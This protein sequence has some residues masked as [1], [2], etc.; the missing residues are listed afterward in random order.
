MISRAQKV[1]LYLCSV[2]CLFWALPA[3]SQPADTIRVL[4]IRVQF[5]TD[6]EPTTTG[7]GTFDLRRDDTMF[8]ID[9]A[10]H[11]R[12]YF[13]DHLRFLQNYYLKVSNRQL[14]VEGDVFPLGRNDAY[15]L[16]N[17]M[18]FY[19]PN[20]TEDEINQGLARLLRDGILKADEDA[21][22]DF[23]RYD[24]FI[25]FH[26]GVGRDIDVGLDDTPQDI[27]SLFI[28]PGFLQT[29][30]GQ[31][32]IPVDNGNFTVDSGI[33]LP[34]TE[35]QEGLELGL[36]GILVSNFGSQLGWLDLFS[37]ETGRSGVG[38]FGV[39]DAG[40]F[41]GD[42]LLPA[43]PTAWTRVSNG[44]A[45]PR[46]IRQAQG[47]VFT[48]HAAGTNGENQ[49]YLVPINQNEYFL[50]E[51]RYAGDISLDSL[52]AVLIDQQNR[53]V[54]MREV[55]ET[56][57]PG[58]ATFSDSTGVLVDVDNP[59][60]GLPGGGILIWHIDEQV[61]AA[62]R[63]ANRI[64][65]DPD[66]R[67]VD[68]EE[69]DGSQDIGEDFEIISGGAGS[70]IGYSLDPWFADNDTPVFEEEPAGTFSV[71]SI[72]SSRSNYNRANSHISV[73]D[74][75]PRDSV[76]TFSVDYNILQPSFPRF[77]DTQ[78]YGRPTGVKVFDVDARPGAEIIVTT[79]Q[80]Q[81]LAFNADRSLISL[82]DSVSLVQLPGAIVGLPALLFTGAVGEPAFAVT[83]GDGNIYGFVIALVT[84][85][86]DTLFR[87]NVG[88][89]ITTFPVTGPLAETA[90]Q[91]ANLVVFGAADG[92][93]YAVTG[94]RPAF[95]LET[96]FNIGQPVRAVQPL[97]GGSFLVIGN[98]GSVFRDGDLDRLL[99]G[100]T[101]QPVGLNSVVSLANSELITL[102][103]P[104]FSQSTAGTFRF[105][106][107]VIALGETNPFTN[108]VQESYAVA[109]NNRLY[110]FNENLSLRTDFPLP[111]YND[112]T[113]AQ[114][115]VS[116]IA[117]SLANF[118]NQNRQGIVFSDPAGV[119]GAAYLDGTAAED[120]PLAAGDS[121]AG[122]P[123]LADIDADGDN[124]LVAVTV[125]G[126]VFAWDLSGDAL[127]QDLWPQENGDAYNRNIS[128]FY[129]NASMLAQDALL[130]ENL[131]YNW[132]NPNVE[133]FTYIR[134][135]LNGPAA[136]TI[137]IFD[138]AGDLVAELD[139]PQV[140]YSDNEVRWNLTDV[141]SGVYFARISAEGNSEKQVN[142]VKIAVIK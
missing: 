48:V 110:V 55:L 88:S 77:V 91:D 67:G 1:S 5:V 68:L 86:V 23:S 69:A 139:A 117:G 109:G 24:S 43:L 63:N 95:Q 100:A 33:L 70:E 105:D 131:A 123:A 42:G 108:N 87:F 57:L 99:S 66:H 45:E 120:F 106:S 65:A 35:S 13:Q 31:A 73:S 16:D 40:L 138:L 27:P 29:Y 128:G 37:P 64:N 136:V 76:M 78:R 17:T 103:E 34:E 140:P 74:F 119:I 137:R 9:P 90:D 62:N 19:N 97:D 101:T 32:G 129:G 50:I 98:D 142:L 51:N 52:Q 30:L 102:N 79:D 112:G 41:N 7:D 3:I 134:Y 20:S 124:E 12:A 60:R 133:D 104:A 94:G 59:D 135:R 127:T 4:A 28:T 44:F 84:S 11:D 80:N 61:I 36:N 26:A 6:S 89:A 113:E 92:N 85:R 21:A 2:C 122:A 111:L 54:S 15:Q 75:S 22:I 130:P 49:V 72:P 47:D 38:R 71:N 96:L 126:S 82:T 114:L 53:F 121:L 81:I 141:Q 18:S 132:P 83:S 93:V 116:P 25:L 14:L 118:N 8:R 115:T 125:S 46:V 39:M 107:P 10:P 56:Q 58:V